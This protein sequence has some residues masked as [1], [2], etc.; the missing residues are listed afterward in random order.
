VGVTVKVS[1][2]GALAAL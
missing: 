1:I 2:P